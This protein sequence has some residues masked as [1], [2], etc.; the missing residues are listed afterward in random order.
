MF[1]VNLLVA[2]TLGKYTKSYG[3]C[4]SKAKLARAL[5]YSELE[6]ADGFDGGGIDIIDSVEA[7]KFKDFFD[8]V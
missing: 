1:T 5:P 8:A 7:G 4:K 3:V 6:R 2:K